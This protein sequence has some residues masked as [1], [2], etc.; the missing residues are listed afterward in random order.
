MKASNL[1]K[2]A[3]LLAPFMFSVG[4]ALGSSPENGNQY[5]YVMVTGSLIPQK[6]RIHSIGTKSAFPLRVYD[7]RE[8]EHTGRV[9]TEDV[10]AQDPSLTVHRGRPTGSQ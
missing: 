5:A 4:T 6:V 9:T 1:A 7:R 8:I 10:L 3:I 2:L